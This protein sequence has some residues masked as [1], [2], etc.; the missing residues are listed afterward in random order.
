MARV[1]TDSRPPIAAAT[2]TIASTV[3]RFS[4]GVGFATQTIDTKDY[5]RVVLGGGFVSIA[6]PTHPKLPQ[7]QH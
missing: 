1:L 3:R 5:G 4:S 6:A 7:G 2:R